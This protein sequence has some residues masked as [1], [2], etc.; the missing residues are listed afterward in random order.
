M[1]FAVLLPAMF[2]YQLVGALHIN[3][4]L[5]FAGCSQYRATLASSIHCTLRRASHVC[6]KP[7]IASW[8]K[9]LIH[10]VKTLKTGTI[11]LSSG[12]SQENAACRAL[13]SSSDFWQ[14]NKQQ[15]VKPAFIFAAPVRFKYQKEGL[16]TAVNLIYIT[17]EFRLRIWLRRIWKLVHTCTNTISTVHQDRNESNRRSRQGCKRRTPFSVLIINKS[18]LLWFWHDRPFL[19]K[20]PLS[21]LD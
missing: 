14:T 19:D 9:T 10:L 21:P 16:L 17:K 1:G 12:Q 7:V 13:F 18:S 5:A 2:A 8:W 4:L 20:H 3:T 11:T 6:E 15:S